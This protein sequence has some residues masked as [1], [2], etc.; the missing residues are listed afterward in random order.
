MKI[1]KKRQEWLDHI[2]RCEKSALSMSAYA[3]R[4]AL[5]LPQFYQIKSVLNKSGMLDQKPIVNSTQPSGFTKVKVAPAARQDL[6]S[7]RCEISLPGGLTFRFDKNTP[8]ERIRDITATLSE[9][10]P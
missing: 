6:A 8:I 3:K 10:C 9:L 4:H 1:T 2:R 7:S 5:N